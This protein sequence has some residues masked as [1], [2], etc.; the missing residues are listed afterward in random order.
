ML[1]N[2]SS[3]I[4]PESLTSTQSCNFIRR[5]RPKAE[6]RYFFGEDHSLGLMMKGGVECRRITERVNI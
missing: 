4:V 6:N 2:G 3:L 1:D 5:S